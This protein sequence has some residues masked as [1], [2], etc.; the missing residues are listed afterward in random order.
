[1]K[2]A[3]DYKEIIPGNKW[4]ETIV[5]RVFFFFYRDGYANCLSDRS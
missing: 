5:V 4:F 3:S 2:A 1:M